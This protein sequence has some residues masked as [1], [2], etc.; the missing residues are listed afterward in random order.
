MDGLTTLSQ[1]KGLGYRLVVTVV[2][3]VMVLGLKAGGSNA[4]SVTLLILIFSVKVNNS[5]KE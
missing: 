3:A 5:A 4:G 2:V 1:G